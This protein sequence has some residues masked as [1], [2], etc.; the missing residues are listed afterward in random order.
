MVQAPPL[1]VT[2]PPEIVQVCAAEELNVAG[3]MQKDSGQRH[4]RI[5]DGIG[6]LN[7]FVPFFRT[8]RMMAPNSCRGEPPTNPYVEV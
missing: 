1:R 6:D 8:S 7:W 2:E 5:A 4:H 3:R